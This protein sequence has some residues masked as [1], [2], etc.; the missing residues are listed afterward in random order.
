M[1]EEII[2]AN[3]GDMIILNTFGFHGNTI[4]KK[5]RLTLIFE[6]RDIKQNQPS[7]INPIS[8][9]K[10]SEKVLK[11]LYLFKVYQNKKHG[12]YM[13]QNNLPKHINPLN[14]IKP[15]IRFIL[16]YFRY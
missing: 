2:T 16:S 8:A 5:A 14:L 15:T 4:L 13:R 7:N 9:V 10:I 11:H 6:F 12:G 3:N 1:K